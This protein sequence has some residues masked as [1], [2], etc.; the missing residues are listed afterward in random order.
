MWVLIQQGRKSESPSFTDE[1]QTIVLSRLFF[2]L[3]S[4]EEG[5][6]CLFVCLFI[7][8]EALEI[9]PRTSGMLSRHPTSELYPPATM[10]FYNTD[11]LM[12]KNV[13]LFVGDS[14]SLNWGS[15][16]AFPIM[17]SIAKVHL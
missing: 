4:W 7:L 15:K 12:R 11:L 1:I 13:I 8:M 16:L 3:V 17:E 5:I 2:P 10:L 9:E 6:V 14:I